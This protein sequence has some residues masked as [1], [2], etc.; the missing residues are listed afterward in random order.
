MEAHSR[1]IG[2]AVILE[3]DSAI[4]RLSATSNERSEVGVCAESF[5]GLVPDG[6]FAGSV[7]VTVIPAIL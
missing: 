3:E 4:K 7:D 1:V 2:V 6:L 5:V